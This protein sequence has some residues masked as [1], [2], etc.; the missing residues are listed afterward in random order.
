MFDN[1]L[2]RERS[3]VLYLFMAQ[4]DAHK[5]SMAKEA[6]LVTQDGPRQQQAVI[7]LRSERVTELGPG[8]CHSCH[9]PKTNMAGP[10]GWCL[11]RRVSIAGLS[12]SPKRLLAWT[13]RPILPG[14]NGVVV[15]SC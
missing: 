12:I 1:E 2:W 5:V 3:I 14:C 10:K 13:G 9:S 11:E 7:A 4:G 8:S 6:V 15:R